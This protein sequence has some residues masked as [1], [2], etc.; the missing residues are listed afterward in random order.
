VIEKDFLRISAEKLRR[1]GSRI[2]DCV[3][4]LNHEQIWTRNA[5]NLNSVGNLVL[6]LCGNVRQWIG[7]GIGELADQRDRDGEFAARGGLE[8]EELI[9]RARQTVSDAIGI[10]GNFDAAR[11]LEKVTIQN[12]EVTKMEAIY[13]VVEHFAQHTGQIMFITKMFTG[14]D[15]GYFKHLNPGAAAHV[16]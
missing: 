15:L 5:D 6:H 10:I 9:Q 2:E 1:S 11:L 4:R 8:P 3:G 7:F 13:Q 16:P 12:Y 14:D